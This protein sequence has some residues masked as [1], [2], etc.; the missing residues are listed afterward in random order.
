[1]LTLLTQRQL[2]PNV[3]LPFGGLNMH[4]LDLL[5]FKDNLLVQNHVC[6]FINS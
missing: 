6:I 1:M 3:Y 5:T 4:T 2:F